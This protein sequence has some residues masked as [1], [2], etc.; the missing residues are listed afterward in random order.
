MQLFYTP[1]LSVPEAIRE[2]GGYPNRGS[3]RETK[4][5][6]Y[7]GSGHGTRVDIHNREQKIMRT[8]QLFS[9]PSLLNDLKLPV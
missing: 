9:L 2:T 4:S 7:T 5:A 6:D 1:F 8:D 3:D